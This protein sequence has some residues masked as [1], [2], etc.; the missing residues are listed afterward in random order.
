M[1]PGRDPLP[2]DHEFEET[3][4][5]MYDRRLWTDAENEGYRATD[6]LLR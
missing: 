1:P 3:P 5:V 6:R 2:D 4:D